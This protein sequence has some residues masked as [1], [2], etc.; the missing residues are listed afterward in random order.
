MDEGCSIAK[1][2]RGSIVRNLDLESFVRFARTN[3]NHLELLDDESV[4]IFF[5]Q[6]VFDIEPPSLPLYGI[7]TVRLFFKETYY[8]A[9]VPQKIVKYERE[10]KLRTHENMSTFYWYYSLF[11]NI[12]LEGLFLVLFSLFFILLPFSMEPTFL[13]T[14]GDLTLFLLIP[15]IYSLLLFT[16]STIAASIFHK[17]VNLKYFN[18]DFLDDM[19]PRGLSFFLHYPIYVWHSTSYDKKWRKVAKVVLLGLFFFG[20]AAFGVSFYLYLKHGFP[21]HLLVLIIF[22][23]STT[24]LFFFLFLYTLPFRMDSFYLIALLVSILVFIVN[25]FIQANYRT[26]VPYFIFSFITLYGIHSIIHSYRFETL[27]RQIDSPVLIVLLV[28]IG[29]SGI[30]GYALFPPD[31]DWLRSFSIGKYWFVWDICFLIL[32]SWLW[33]FIKLKHKFGKKERYPYQYLLQ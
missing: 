11:C 9:L 19:T 20:F 33:L 32:V 3:K 7:K 22:M 21:S 16:T 26:V 25:T 1:D 15:S 8:R 6:L 4:W 10:K 29:V 18:D 30:T 28:L 24:S 13:L 23:G 2:L 27:L 17:T 12:T 14:P 31:T 5:Y